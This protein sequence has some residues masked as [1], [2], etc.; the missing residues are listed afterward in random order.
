MA[1]RVFGAFLRLVGYLLGVAI[2]IGMVAIARKG[3][4]PG[5]VFGGGG[6]VMI[7]RAWIHA[8]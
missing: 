1:E 2:D 8:V 7:K 3:L 5:G 4:L 6:H